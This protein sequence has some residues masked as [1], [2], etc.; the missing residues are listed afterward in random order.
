MSYQVD[1]KK[2]IENKVCQNAENNTGTGDTNKN[3]KHVIS[4]QTNTL[5]NT[6]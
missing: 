4:S 6:W 3:Y 5:H 2:Q 1:R